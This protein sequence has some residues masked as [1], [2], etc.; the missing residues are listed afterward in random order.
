M[1]VKLIDQAQNHVFWSDHV[2]AIRQALVATMSRLEYPIPWVRSDY[3]A[4][5]GK[6]EGLAH[7]VGYF[8]NGPIKGIAR[9]KKTTDKKI[10]SDMP[11]DTFKAFCLGLCRM[12]VRMQSKLPWAHV[13]DR[14]GVISKEIAFPF[15]YP[16]AHAVQSMMFHFPTAEA[17]CG[18]N[19]LQIPQ[20]EFMA[21]YRTA[22]CP[23]N[24]RYISDICLKSCSRRSRR[25]RYS[26]ISHVL[27]GDS[28]VT[29]GIWT[30]S[31]PGCLAN[32]RQ[33]CIFVLFRT[34]IL[35]F[36]CFIFWSSF[37]VPLF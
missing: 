4:L 19:Q 37:V 7:L 30:R 3:V 2:V 31:V 14:H 35:F 34:M 12:G 26:T 32:G 9:L 28:S 20:R 11:V 21:L 1:V 33:Y 8:F 16:A 25:K 27:R 18:T 36:V 22:P 29:K 24:S 13:V 23:P 6:I 17:C 15:Q 5:R 10:V